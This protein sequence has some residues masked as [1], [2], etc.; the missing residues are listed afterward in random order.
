MII[1]RNCSW[2]GLAWIWH[3]G[4]AE[5]DD[6]WCVFRRLCELASVPETAW[7]AF[8]ADQSAVVAVNG[9]VIHHGPPREVPPFAYYDVLDLRPY[10]RAGANELR[11][12]VHWPGVRTHSHSPSVRGLMAQGCIGAIDLAT[13]GAWQAARDPAHLRP[14]RRLTPFVGWAELVHLPAPEPA[15]AAPTVQGAHPLPGRDRLLPRDLPALGGAVIPAQPTAR[16]GIRDCGRT[17]SGRVQAHLRVDRPTTVRITWSEQLHEGRVLPN[18][19]TSGLPEGYGDVL[20]LEPGDHHWTSH[21]IRAGRFI[22]VDPPQAPVS[23]AVAEA[24]W[25]QPWDHARQVIGQATDALGARMLEVS[26]R[27]MQVCTDDI[28]NDCPTR[29]RAQYFDCFFW[30]GAFGLLFGNLDPIRRFLRQYLRGAGPDGVLQMK[31][32]APRDG[33]VIPDFAL[34]LSVQLAEFL[35]RTGEVATVQGLRLPALASVRGLERWCDGDGLLADVPGWIFLDNGNEILKHPRSAALNAC[36]LGALRAQARLAEVCGDAAMADSLHARCAAVRAAW[37]RVF[38]QPEAGRILDGDG[39]PEA[40][41]WHVVGHSL[42]MEGPWWQVGAGA[43]V[44]LRFRCAGT[45]LRLHG[46]A[47]VRAFL[48]GRLLATGDPD[49]TPQAPLFHP[50]ASGALPGDD[51]WHELEVHSRKGGWEWELLL[52]AD[53]AITCVDE[54][55]WPLPSWPEGATPQAEPVATL[56][57]RLLPHPV[58]RRSQLTAGYAIYHGCLDFDEAVRVLRDVTPE[59]LVTPFL[60]RTT[61]FGVEVSHDPAELRDRVVAANCPSSLYHLCHALR[62]HGLEDRAWQEVR[63]ACLPQLARG[64]TTWWEEFRDASSLCHAWG[65]FV[66]EFVPRREVSR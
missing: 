29:E 54:R 2:D 41:R 13:P 44:R 4:A 61:P 38:W 66:A 56:P 21:D 34:L 25:Q 32:P 62:R 12:T 6:A 43:V 10:L 35:E 19:W 14:S 50:V 63:R 20:E 5:P 33:G 37:R 65:A 18:C 7:L 15:W 52:S 39:S 22:Q 26:A 3:A 17:V 11:I 57:T 51:G 42:P 64:A 48:D 16:A 47:T 8:T 30:T 23:L 28:L 36:Y 45:E 59:R 31:Y 27:T 9:V 49:R 58:A 24:Q 1:A 55:W 60:R 46:P 40:E 53:A